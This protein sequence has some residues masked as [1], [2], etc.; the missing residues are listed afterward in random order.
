MPWV[1]NV[2]TFKDFLSL[3]IVHAPDDFPKE[4]Y[5]APDE[6]LNLARAFGELYKGLEMLLDSRCSSLQVTA[7]RGILDRALTAYRSGEDVKGAHLLQEF[8]AIAFK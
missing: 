2:P 1:K 7:L 5:L 4:D 8:E 6:Q 3:V